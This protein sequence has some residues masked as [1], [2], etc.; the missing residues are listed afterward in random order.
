MERIVIQ[1][2]GAVARKWRSSS[3]E[4]KEEVVQLVSTL[5]SERK[6]D[7]TITPAT[8]AQEGFVDYLDKLRDRMEQ[9][10]LT[11][12]KLDDILRDE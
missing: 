9:R 5:I 12:E 2:D 7:D 4:L 8:H 11:Q 1:V 10:G 6:Y 3:R